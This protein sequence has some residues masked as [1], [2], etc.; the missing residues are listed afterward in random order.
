[1]HL[2]IW[3]GV[4]IRKDEAAVMAY[5]GIFYWYLATETEKISRKLSEQ[6]IHRP[7]VIWMYY[8]CAHPLPPAVFI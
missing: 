2:L 1:M 4:T 8:C 3:C 7:N 5:F 6:K